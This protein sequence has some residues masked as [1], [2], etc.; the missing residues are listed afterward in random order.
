M[1][2]TLE[3]GSNTYHATSPA[4]GTFWLP[5]SLTP[6]GLE[7][8]GLP[9]WPP[10]RSLGQTTSPTRALVRSSSYSGRLAASKVLCSLDSQDFANLKPVSPQRLHLEGF[11]A[12]PGAHIDFGAKFRNLA[13]QPDSTVCHRRP[14][15]SLGPPVD[16]CPP[17]GDQDEGAPVRSDCGPTVAQSARSTISASSNQPRRASPAASHRAIG[18]TERAGSRSHRGLGPFVARHWLVPAPSRGFFQSLRPG[19]TR[20]RS[21]QHAP[22]IQKSPLTHHRASGI[23]GLTSTQ[24]TRSNFTCNTPDAARQRVHSGRRLSLRARPYRVATK[25]LLS[26]SHE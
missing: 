25:R 22:R 17:A 8:T 21:T 20:T 10:Q 12:S 6:P 24:A 3:V 2:F 5:D 18:P 9:V 15:D 1:G 7:H 11:K 13:N 19:R 23:A 14:F 26:Q 4:R 16:P